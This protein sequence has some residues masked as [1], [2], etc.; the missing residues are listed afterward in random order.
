MY[1]RKCIKLTSR[2]FGT[3]IFIR[4]HHSSA[5]I[6][7]PVPDRKVMRHCYSVLLQLSTKKRY[8][9]GAIAVIWIIIPSLEITFTTVTRDIVQGAC[10]RFPIYNSDAVR[11]AIGFLSFFVSYLLPLTLMVFCYARIVRALQ[12][13]VILLIKIQS[14]NFLNSMLTILQLLVVLINKGFVTIGVDPVEK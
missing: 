4:P 14:N 7:E 3:F 6:S 5:T 12:S 11:K 9:Y 1:E 13:Q 2:I 10:V 8:V